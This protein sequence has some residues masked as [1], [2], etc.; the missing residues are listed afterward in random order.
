M[1]TAINLPLMN[2][3]ERAAVGTC[4]KRQGPDAALALGHQLV[5]GEIRARRL[6]AWKGLR[7]LSRATCALAAPA[8]AYRPAVAEGSGRGLPADRRRLQSA[9]P[10][11]DTAYR[12]AGAAPIVLIGGCTGN[13]KTQ[14]VG[15]QPDGIDRRLAHHRG[16]S[17]G[18]T[19][20]SSISGQPLKITWPWPC[21]KS[22]QQTRWVLGG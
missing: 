2:D 10:G 19:L 12:R 6:A 22:G 1:P 18:R 4:Y 17:F 5:N 7:A 3:D 8:F 15:A 11:G 13:G 16:S 14:L 20:R 21:S 9:A